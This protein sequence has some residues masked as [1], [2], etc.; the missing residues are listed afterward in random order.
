MVGINCPLMVAVKYG[1]KNRDVIFV[2]LEKG[3]CGFHF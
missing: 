2:C 1:L 3:F